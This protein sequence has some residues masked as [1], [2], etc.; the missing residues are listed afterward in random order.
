MLEHRPILRNTLYG[1][2]AFAFVFS[3]A[4][5]GSALMITGGLDFGGDAH[6]PRA[7][8]AEPVSYVVLPNTWPSAPRTSYDVTPASA[9]ADEAALEPAYFETAA[10]LEGAAQPDRYQD[11]PNEDEIRAQ[12]ERNYYASAYGDDAKPPVN[13]FVFT[14]EGVESETTEPA[15][16]ASLW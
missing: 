5:G 10:D 8:Q 6:E 13:D 16:S 3:A 4:M 7:A 12:I 15:E 1:A 14:D 11:Y 9:M 2:A